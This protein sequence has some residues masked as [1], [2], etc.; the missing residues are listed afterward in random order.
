MGN[1]EY[2]VDIR[3][4]WQS[5][6]G[7]CEEIGSGGEPPEGWEGVATFK[8]EDEARRFADRLDKAGRRMRP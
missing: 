7:D 6:D 3:I 8:T 2:V 5:D 1:D 4:Y